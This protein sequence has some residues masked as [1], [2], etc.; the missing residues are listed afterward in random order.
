MKKLKVIDPAVIAAIVEACKG[1][2]RDKL[3]VFVTALFRACGLDISGFPSLKATLDVCLADVTDIPARS[4]KLDL[5]R[6]MGALAAEAANGFSY[7][8][9]MG[10]PEF[11]RYNSRSG[12]QRA[13]LFIQVITYISLRVQLDYDGF[14]FE[15]LRYAADTDPVIS[16]KA[17]TLF[18]V[19][20]RPDFE[21]FNNKEDVSHE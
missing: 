16:A 1:S 15:L 17:Q 6:V 14:L 2:T 4:G 3:V 18:T 11:D 8:V 5:N 19:L 21:N 20:S 9:F 12:E 10:Q 13:L 7:F